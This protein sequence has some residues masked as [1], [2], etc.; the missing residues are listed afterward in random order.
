MSKQ[1]QV[2]MK[3]DEK[4]NATLRAYCSQF[5]LPMAD[6]LTSLCLWA[7]DNAPIQTYPCLDLGDHGIFDMNIDSP[8]QLRGAKPAKKK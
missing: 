6:M 8:R 2:Q 3:M 1:V 4:E 7:V 5:D